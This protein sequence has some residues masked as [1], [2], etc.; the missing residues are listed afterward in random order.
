[1]GAAV[2]GLGAVASI[3]FKAMWSREKTLHK[4]KL[5]SWE[6]LRSNPEFKENVKRVIIDEL[7]KIAIEIAKEVNNQ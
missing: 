5:K 3:G 4:E 1:M 6:L 2:I 7:T